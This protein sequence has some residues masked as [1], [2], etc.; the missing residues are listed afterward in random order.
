MNLKVLVIAVRC[1]C[2]VDSNVGVNIKRTPAFRCDKGI[3]KPNH[4]LKSSNFNNQLNNIINQAVK[5]FDN[6]TNSAGSSELNCNGV[7]HD[8]KPS[9]NIQSNG[10]PSVLSRTHHVTK[11]PDIPLKPN[12]NYATPTKKKPT[13]PN[14][15]PVDKPPSRK[16]SHS[17][18]ESSEVGTKSAFHSELKQVLSS[19]LPSGPPPKKPPRT[20]AH[21]FKYCPDNEFNSREPL[22]PNIKSHCNAPSSL[23][24]NTMR[25]IRSKTESQ[26][27]LKKLENV[28]KQHPNLSDRSNNNEPFAKNKS[29]SKDARDPTRR[30]GIC[31]GLQESERFIGALSCNRGNKEEHV[32]AEVS[33]INKNK[34]FNNK[35][36]GLHYM[37]SPVQNVKL[38]LPRTQMGD[39]SSPVVPLPN[40]TDSDSKI[41][42]SDSVS[43]NNKKIQSWVNEAYDKVLSKNTDT[44]SD[45]DSINSVPDDNCPPLKTVTNN[46][47]EQLTLERKGY[48]KRVSSHGQYHSVSN[49]P[50]GSPGA[51]LFEQPLLF[52]IIVNLKH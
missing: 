18:S 9:I 8:S 52:L 44:S 43:S 6:P 51:N 16:T 49:M 35:N 5:K 3:K 1:K 30:Y 22:S 41:F 28:L 27:M 2:A 10:K 47:Q 46:N 32:Y 25:P 20:F 45:S 48:L 19:P 42:E 50:A 12:V 17:V 21:N 23:P 26:I 34:T 33:T 4:I 24:S 15:L 36:Q 14:Y 29:V 7:R 38:V 39:P 37:S 31:L 13:R 40:L 11:H